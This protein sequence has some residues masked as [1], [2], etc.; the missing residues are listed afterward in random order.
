MLIEP[1]PYL[2]KVKNADG[3]ERKD[4]DGTTNVLKRNPD[5]CIHSISSLERASSLRL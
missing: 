3:N 2:P 1:T 5:G 4:E